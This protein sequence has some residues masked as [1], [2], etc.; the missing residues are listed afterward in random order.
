MQ[1]QLGKVGAMTICDE[2]TGVLFQGALPDDAINQLRGSK[3]S[4]FDHVSDGDA[5]SAVDRSSCEQCAALIRLIG[6]RGAISMNTVSPGNCAGA[7][8]AVSPTQAVALAFIDKTLSQATSHVCQAEIGLDDHSS[9][10]QSAIEVGGSDVTLGAGSVRSDLVL[11]PA[12]Q[13]PAPLTVRRIRI[14]SRYCIAAERL[15]SEID[16]LGIGR[17]FNIEIAR[18]WYDGWRRMDT[19]GGN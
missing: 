12:N 5:H 6:G 13:L 19:K 7:E 11:V 4:A 15:G 2:T 14:K 17:S 8:A 10:I 18:Y 16:K 3:S 9:G 1:P